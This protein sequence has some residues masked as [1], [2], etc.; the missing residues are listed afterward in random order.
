MSR[1]GA[2]I[3]ECPHC[4]AYLQD[5]AQIKSALIAIP[6]PDLRQRIWHIVQAGVRYP[7]RRILVPAGVWR[8]AISIA[9]VIVLITLF[10]QVLHF[11][12][13]HTKPISLIPTA[14]L[15]PTMFPTIAATTIPRFAGWTPSDPTFATSLAFAASDH[16]I[17]YACGIVPG[18]RAST[19]KGLAFI[20]GNLPLG[21]THDGG[22]T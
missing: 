6:E 14:T 21:V 2:H 18:I 20:E 17:G 10:V 1:I 16:L 15:T 5:F 9:S 11:A 3:G 8:G 12:G 4:Q 19:P 13:K 22:T 7:P